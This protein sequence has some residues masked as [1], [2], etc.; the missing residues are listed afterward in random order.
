MTIGHIR[1]TLSS[2]LLQAL[3]TRK[4]HP[5]VAASTLSV[6]PSGN[7]GPALTPT[8]GGDAA[9]IKPQADLTLQGFERAWG[10]A[11]AAYDLDG[12]GVVD[13]DD[14]TQWV[15]RL[16]EQVDGGEPKPKEPGPGAQPPQPAPLTRE[17]FERAWGTANEQYDLDGSGTVDMDDW[18]RWSLNLPAITPETE[19]TQPTL[20][21]SDGVTTGGFEVQN[22]VD[23]PPNPATTGA[24]GPTLEGVSEAWGGADPV[25]DVNGDGMVNIDDYTA[26]VL[27]RQQAATQADE[28]A[29]TLPAGPIGPPAPIEKPRRVADLLP[30][31]EVRRK[32]GRTDDPLTN[33]LLLVLRRLRAAGMHDRN[34]FLAKMNG[35]KGLDEAMG[36]ATSDVDARTRS[37]TSQLLHEL[38]QSGFASR[39]PG[40]IRDLV[41]AMHLD[42]S[43]EKYVMGRLG[44]AYP[45]GLGINATA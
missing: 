1:Q 23:T 10:T 39:P 45:G 32:G 7:A 14:V 16:A 33:R 26:V 21:A 25:N 3:V 41:S 30:P 9:L 8:S 28:Q 29:K 44:S 20:Q 17:G 5:A 38:K 6:Q 22:G 27:G 37:L 34:V 19:A 36:L 2:D 12:S 35:G 31:I 13:I 11:D 40:N 43:Q 18:T 24:A 42:P 15:L 4:Q